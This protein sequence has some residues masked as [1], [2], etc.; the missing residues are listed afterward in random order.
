[1]Q[2]DM[3]TLRQRAHQELVGRARPGQAVD[4]TL[5]TGVIGELAPLLDI[6]AVQ[7]LVDAVLADVNGLGP[8][9]PLLASDDV[10]DVMVVGGH[11]VWIERNGQ[12]ELTDIQL[13]NNE[14]GHLIERIVAP[15]GLRIDRSVDARLADGSRVNAVVPPLAVDGPCLSIRRFGARPI[16][17]AEIARPEPA[18]LL[19]KAVTQ[20]RNIVVIGGTGAGK[21]TLLNALA[22]HIPSHERVIT[23]EDAAE[24]RLPLTHVVRLEG[25]PANSEGVGR[26]TLREL[27]RNALRMRPDRIVVGEVR[28]A[29]A[30]DML[31]AMNT[32]H[33][34]S[35]STCHANTPADALRRIETMVL[36]GDINLPLSAV[37]EQI[38][39]SI[40][41]VVQV[42]RT[43]S[44]SRQVV[45]IS[46]VTNV[47]GTIGV[48]RLATQHEV[49]AD[50]SRPKRREVSDGAR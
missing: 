16:D 7:F 42:A 28:G 8:L 32:G 31:Q 12:L 13:D 17:L 15:L 38:G 1:V 22:S 50:E 19:R 46:E 26:V 24:L 18:E 30:L 5:V 37:R 36:M 23:V 4:A 10:T 33:E 35:M 49:V 47:D 27:V 21:T 34:G 39:A 20:Y 3:A 9:E 14:V 41:L 2:A 44:A 6:A 29:E 48:R 40:D 43:S 25:R 45:D 11:G